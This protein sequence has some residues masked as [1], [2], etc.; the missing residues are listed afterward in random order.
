MFRIEVSLPSPED[1]LSHVNGAHHRKAFKGRP[2][3]RKATC[4]HPASDPAVFARGRLY[5]HEDYEG[6]F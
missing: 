6:P 5:M 1:A 2:M 4:D 3:E